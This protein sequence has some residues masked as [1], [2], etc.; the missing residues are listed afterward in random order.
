[1]KQYRI[2]MC[3]TVDVDDGKHIVAPYYKVYEEEDGHDCNL[4]FDCDTM[5]EAKLCIEIAKKN[6]DWGVAEIMEAL[7]AERCK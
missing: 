6:P 1:M 3:L 5:S 7:Y 2:A 4:L